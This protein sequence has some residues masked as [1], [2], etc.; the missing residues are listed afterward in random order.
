VGGGVQPTLFDRVGKE[1]MVVDERDAAN[2]TLSPDGERLAV[3]PASPAVWIRDLRRRTKTRLTF[4]T[5]PHV[6]ATWSPDGTQQMAQS[7][8]CR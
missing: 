5:E 4:S 2:C 3:S 7:L 6:A 8:L 1:L